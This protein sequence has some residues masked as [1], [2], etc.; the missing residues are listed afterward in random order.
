MDTYLQR[1]RDEIQ[2][3]T[4]GLTPGQIG[5]PVAGKWSIAEILEHLTLAFQVNA[6]GLEKALAAR[7]TR[8][9][10]PKAAEWLA[11]TLVI[12]A[13]YFPRARA[14]AAAVPRG[15]IPP[16]RSVATLLETLSVLDATLTRAAAAFGEDRPVLN[17]PYFAG[18][19]VRR[20]RKF[21]WRHVRHH[22]R[23]LRALA[24]S[25]D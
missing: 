24:D 6:T 7:Q 2:E 20:W 17:H 5:R 9:R 21:H 11:G 23:Q 13:G 3:A 1:A 16:E 22:V 25:S 19:S 10:R 8:T 4:R 18:L 14:P 12:D 15:S